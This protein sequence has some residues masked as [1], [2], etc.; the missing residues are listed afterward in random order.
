MGWGFEEKFS[1]IG[2]KGFKDVAIRIRDRLDAV[3]LEF[4]GEPILP[5]AVES[6]TPATGLGRISRNGFN[7]ELMESSSNLGEI[8]Q[9]DFASCFGSVEEV[10]CTVR[11]ERAEDSLRNDH[12]VKAQHAFPGGFFGGQFGVIDVVVGIIRDEN[13]RLFLR[14]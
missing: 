14:G 13:E 1:V 8:G 2:Q 12:V 6:L 5:G 4:L 10:P 11:I 7:A 3:K 9:I